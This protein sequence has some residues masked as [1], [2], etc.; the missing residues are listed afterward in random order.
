[1]H[2]PYAAF[3]T[4]VAAA[5]AALKIIQVRINSSSSRRR[6]RRR[7]LGR[8]DMGCCSGAVVAIEKMKMHPLRSIRRHCGD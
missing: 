7:C 5:A 1:M 4:A 8:L 3:T 2:F 6:G